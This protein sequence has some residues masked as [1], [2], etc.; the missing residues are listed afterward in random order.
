ML[1]DTVADNSLEHEEPSVKVIAAL[2]AVGLGSKDSDLVD[3]AVSELET[4]APPRRLFQDPHG[5]ADLVLFAN[6]LV[7]GD[8]AG[9]LAAFETAAMTNPY[10]AAPRN[11]L[12][13]AYIAAGKTSEAVSLLSNVREPHVEDA[14]EADRVRG[15][16]ATLE[17]EE[18]TASL[19]RAVMLSPWDEKNWEA[20]AWAKRA[21]TEVDA[22]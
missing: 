5:A 19:Q 15:I 9:A 21:V 13:E 1:R 12:A 2:G 18:S 20:L 3:A 17:G 16:A 10:A 11:R 4:V 22:E 7:E 14:A 8:E 6:S